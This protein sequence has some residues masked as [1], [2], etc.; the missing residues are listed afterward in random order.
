M[1]KILSITLLSILPVFI[2]AQNI[3]SDLKKISQ[4]YASLTNTK[5]SFTQTILLAKAEGLDKNEISSTGE[6]IFGEKGTR[7]IF[8]K[9]MD[10]YEWENKSLIVDKQKREISILPSY[11]LG[12]VV[13][14]SQVQLIENLE[15]FV[16]QSKEVKYTKVNSNLFRYTLLFNG[17]QKL[18]LE[19]NSS[20]RVLSL[21]VENLNQTIQEQGYKQLLIKFTN[22]PASKQELQRADY[23]NV[24]QANKTKFILSKEYKSYHLVNLQ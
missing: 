21:L 24:G 18:S 4:N 16:Q 5:I 14:N 7:T 17:N 6:M 19:F 22:S 1:K 3:E 8:Q 15:L 10:V 11:Q 2:W 9:E 12:K 20:Y 13:T 23:K